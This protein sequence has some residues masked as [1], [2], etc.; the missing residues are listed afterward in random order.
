MISLRFVWPIVGL[1]LLALVPTALN[2]YADPE[3][4]RAGELAARIPARLSGFRGPADGKRAATWIHQY[5][6][7]L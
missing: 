3:P 5:L 7:S 1:L 6:R 4:L 2:K